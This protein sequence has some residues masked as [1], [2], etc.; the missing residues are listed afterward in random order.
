MARFRNKDPDHP[1]AQ[2]SRIP[3][4]RYND[5]TKGIVSDLAA[6]YNEVGGEEASKGKY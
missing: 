4:E 1:A 6:V 2:G 3:T 5:L